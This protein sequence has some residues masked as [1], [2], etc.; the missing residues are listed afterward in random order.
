[1][2]VND[3]FLKVCEEAARAAGAVLLEWSP[4]FSVREKGP[5]DL[6]TE[7]DVAAQEEIQRRILDKFPDHGFLGEESGKDINPGAEHRWI[8]DPLDGTTNYVHQV[9][10]YCVS[11]GLEHNGELIVGVIYDPVSK[12]CY[13]AT[14]G[15]GAFLNGT[16]RLQVRDTKDLG[17]ALVSTSIS[18]R[19]QP[20]SA[21]MRDL[22]QIVSRCRTV[23]RMGSAA[24]NLCQIAAGRFDAYWAENNKAWDIAAGFVIL[25]E[26][27]G[28][29]AS[30]D[31][32]EVDLKNPKFIAACTPELH[33][34]MCSFMS[35]AQ[36]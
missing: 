35:S 14:K 26:A 29:I 5:A 22:A 1:M 24:L 3:E 12:D 17:D 11:I 8:V 16:Q 32:S 30:L 18:P 21:E 28:Y 31:G 15:G 19:A 20:E 2:A 9:A 10:Y 13:T 25:R 23:R 4:R 7:A 27:G 34:E 36:G 33:A 6:V